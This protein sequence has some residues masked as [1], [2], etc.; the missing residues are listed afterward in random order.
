MCGIVAYNGPKTEDLNI[1]K[2]KLLLYGN[3]ER[4]K[5]SLGYYT[6]ECGVVKKLGLPETILSTS[7][8]TISGKGMFIGHVRAATSGAKIEQNAHP[9]KHDNIILVMNGTLSNHFELAREYGLDIKKFDVDSD[10]LTAIIAKTQNEVAL[11][12][13]K[14]GCAVVFTD[15]NTD[16][17]Y[18]YRNNDRP[19]YRGKLGN[20]MYISSMLIPL[21]IIGCSDVKEFKDGYLYTIE[22]GEILTQKVV[23]PVI[24]VIKPMF[25][26]MLRNTKH[27]YSFSFINADR[28]QN[29]MLYQLDNPKDLI[30]KSLMCDTA[31]GAYYDSAL[32]FGR[33]YRI[34]GVDA[35]NVTIFDDTNTKKSVP[36]RR[37]SSK[38]GIFDI[39][40]YVFTNNRLNYTTKKKNKTVLFADEDVL[41]EIVEIDLDGEKLYIKNVLTG[42]YATV[43]EDD[44]RY[45]W[46]KDVQEFKEL[47]NI[48]KPKAVTEPLVLDKNNSGNV[49]YPVLLGSEQG[50]QLGRA[51]QSMLKAVEKY[52]ES[53]F[54][55]KHETIE[56]LA[57]FSISEISDLITN[58]N[59]SIPNPNLSLDF[60]L[61]KIEAILDNYT[62]KSIFLSKPN[63]KNIIGNNANS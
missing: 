4:G 20:S 36:K 50:H 13:I 59:E 44:V 35:E 42:S 8:F 3:Q 54:E 32:T 56:E 51:K 28:V 45:A 5:D 29:I 9:F 10:I 33:G 53:V 22:N 24:E 43:P 15:T 39:G 7:T 58:I 1:D 55:T 12:K 61:K 27:P 11:T 16:K 60:K 48:D 23:K 52:K 31:N 18:V 40:K 41:C 6:K 17:M 37:F 47:Y 63:E 57:D 62:T 34:Y 46:D 30:G 38:L 2:L 14:G 49:Q 25:L 19:L 21:K 26:G